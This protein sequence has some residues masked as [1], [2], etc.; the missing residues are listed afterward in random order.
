M[1][2][3]WYRQLFPKLAFAEDGNCML[4][5]TTTMG[6]GRMAVKVGGSVNL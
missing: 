1:Q 5:M 6:G 4:E 3:A 2:S